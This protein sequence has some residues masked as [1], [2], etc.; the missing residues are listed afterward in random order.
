MKSMKSRLTMVIIIT[1]VV[2]IL[3]IN[4]LSYY[5]IARLVRQNVENMTLSNLQQTKVS[6]DVW[7]ESYEDLLFQIYTNDDIVDLV[8]KINAGEDVANNRQTLRRLLR[9]LFYTKDYVKAITVITESG[10][11]AFYDQLTTSV[12]NALWM[13]SIPM[14][15]EELYREISSDNKTHILTTGEQIIFGTNSCYL[16]HIGHRI[17]DYRNTVKQCGAVIVSID[18]ELLREV[19][20]STEK[21]LGKYKD[22]LNFIVD[23]DGIV[24]SCANSTETG[25]RIFKENADGAKREEAFKR[26]ALD[27][28]IFKTEDLFLYSLY[29]EEMNWWIIRA[30]GQEELI[31]GLSRQQKMQIGLTLLS[32]LAVLLIMIWQINRMTGSVDRVVATMRKAGKEDLFIH[33]LPDEERPMEIEIIAQ[34][35]NAAMDKL[36][37][38]TEN[39]KNAEIAALEAQINPHFLYNTL[40]T[41]NWMAIGKEEYEISN[42]IGALAQILR[43]GISKSNEEVTIREE[44]N[45]LKQYL[46]LQQTRIKNM[47][48]CQIDIE[49]ELMEVRIHKLLLQPFVE[50]VILHGFEGINHRACLKIGIKRREDEIVI[51]IEDNGQGMPEDFVRN[52]N[53]GIFRETDNRSHIGIENAV[54]RLR[55]YYGS[56]AGFQVESELGKGTIIRIMIPAGRKEENT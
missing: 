23:Q 24:V 21:Q 39:Q 18:E 16:F 42:M 47:F 55:M 2:P 49:P 20:S 54:T 36:K 9:R 32:L 41:I 37:I 43:Y 12:S 10:E 25:K 35:F 31:G 29:D 34:E 15:Q 38:S 48:E 4:I 27:S 26:L 13:D 8:D 5:N 40:D 14:T 6:L 11:L 3:I 44:A 30:A 1:S 46:F 53:R 52:L 22:G 17:I 28:G 19:C 45:W 33:V 50:N 7:L 51:E 56:R